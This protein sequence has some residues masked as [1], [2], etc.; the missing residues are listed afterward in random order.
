MNQK[1][2]L[3][4]RKRSSLNLIHQRERSGAFTNFKSL[5]SVVAIYS[6]T[7]KTNETNKV[8]HFLNWI[9]MTNNY[10]GSFDRSCLFITSSVSLLDALLEYNGVDRLVLVSRVREVIWETV[11]IV[12]LH[13][14][15]SPFDV[16][17]SVELF[18]AWQG[19]S[20]RPVG[21]H[22]HYWVF[23]SHYTLPPFPIWR[24]A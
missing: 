22:Y 23:L 4:K 24:Y 20:I 2:Y 9:K 21:E 8:A 3:V 5:L 18:E 12:L 15:H 1:L 19:E 6:R 17:L 13:P 10:S 14:P 16:P 7:A 11:S